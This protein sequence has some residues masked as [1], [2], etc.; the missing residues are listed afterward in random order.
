MLDEVV[1]KAVQVFNFQFFFFV[2]VFL[3]NLIQI[4]LHA[5][6][7]AKAGTIFQDDEREKAH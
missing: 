7:A 2:P 3:H 4:F 6:L 5:L 1:E